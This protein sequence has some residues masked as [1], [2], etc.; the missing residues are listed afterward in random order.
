[1]AANGK[2]TGVDAPA[3][4]PSGSPLVSALLAATIVGAFSVSPMLLARF[5]VAYDTV[6]GNALQKIHPATFVGALALGAGV[7][8]GGRPVAKLKRIIARLPGATL[9]FVLWILLIAFSVM[10]QHSPISTLLDNYLVALIALVL[11][12]DVMPKT[13]VFVRRYLHTIM[14]FN[15][16]IGVVEL[17]AHVRFIPYVIGGVEI[18][19]DYRSTALLGHPLANAATTGAYLLCLFLGGDRSLT[20][21]QRFYLMVPQILAMVAFGGRTAIVFAS[22]VIVLGVLKSLALVLLGKSVD[23]RGAIA[24]FL[25]LPLLLGFGIA[26]DSAGAFDQLVER[27]TDDN[28]SAL[29]RVIMFRLFDLFPLEDILWG[30][31][32]GL[33]SSALAT[34]GIPIGIENT[35]ISLIFQYGAFMTLFFVIGLCALCWEIWRRAQ[36]GALLLFIYFI[37]IISSATGLASK[38]YL[39]AQFVVFLLFLFSRDDAAREQQPHAL[40]VGQDMPRLAY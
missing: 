15:A 16:L 12:D 2:M 14:L 21:A 7:F 23:L 32:P 24:L 37:G 25:G 39:F 34:L 31:D 17:V 10:V 33:V 38:T 27:F 8:A 36:S 22:A 35:W 19:S 4:S 9:F 1:M 3:E 6:G 29:A 30:P 40:P 18:L 13:R 11:F 5:G 20:G 28:G 26:A